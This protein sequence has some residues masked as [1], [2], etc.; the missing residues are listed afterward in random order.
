MKKGLSPAAARLIQSVALP[1]I[2]SSRN[3]RTL[4]SSSPTGWDFSPF[5][6][7]QSLGVS[8]PTSLT[9]ALNAAYED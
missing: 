5:L 3:G 2:I 9:S 7:C 4:R 1:T 8:A 6:P